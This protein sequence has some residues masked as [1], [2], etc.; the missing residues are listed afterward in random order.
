M[1]NGLGVRTLMSLNVNVYVAALYVT[2]PS[3]DANTTLAAATP[4]ELI[5]HFVHD[6]TARAMTDVWDEGFAHNAR[7]QLPI[8][9]DRIA[10]L[11]GWMTPM[12]VGR[13]MSFSFK[14]GTGVTVTVNGT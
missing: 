12:K 7:G 5:L 2:K 10:T 3:D 6:V 1:L 8:L 11:N 4:S 13:R 14:P 9:K